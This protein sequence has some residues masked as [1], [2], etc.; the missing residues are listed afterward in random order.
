MNVSV[1]ERRLNFLPEKEIQ[2]SLR[3]TI[4]LQ[5]FPWAEAHGYRH[6][7]AP[8]DL[9]PAGRRRSQ[10]ESIIEFLFDRPRNFC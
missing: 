1:A 2:V 5:P 8:R 4:G 7:L 9:K 6:D 10:E 3:D